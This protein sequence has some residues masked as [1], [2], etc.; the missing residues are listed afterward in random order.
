MT[1][2]P[3]IGLN[4]LRNVCVKQIKLH[5]TNVSTPHLGQHLAL[6]NHN[7]DSERCLIGILDQLNRQ[8]IRKRFAVVLLL[9]AVVAQSLAKVSVTIEQPD[10]DEWQAE[11]A[12][13]LEMIAREYPQS[14]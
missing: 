1:S 8:V 4:V 5:P 7:F 13:R 11:I 14:A 10:C 3:A 2:H 6:A 12:G 9:P